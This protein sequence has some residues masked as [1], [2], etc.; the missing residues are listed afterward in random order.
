V[1]GA[2]QS[3]SLEPGGAVRD[4]AGVSGQSFRDEMLETARPALC[5]YAMS[6][7]LTHHSPNLARRHRRARPIIAN[8][9]HRQANNDHRQNDTLAVMQI[10]GDF[11]D[12]IPP[13][14][15]MG[16]FSEATTST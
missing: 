6:M 4:S 8:N 5:R 16:T 13:Q 1:P 10:P 9:D 3:G 12:A 11:S 15:T 14:A 7:D 2:D